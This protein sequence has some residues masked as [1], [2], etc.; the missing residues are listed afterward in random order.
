M[1]LIP[2]VL[3]AM[4]NENCTF[5]F[6]LLNQLAPFHANSSSECWRTFGIAPE[7]KSL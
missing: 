5:C 7:D 6:D 3:P 2:I 4:P 1:I